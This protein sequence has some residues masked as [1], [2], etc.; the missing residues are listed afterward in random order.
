MT[1]TSSR[2]PEGTRARDRAAATTAGRRQVAVLAGQLVAGLGNLVVSVLLARL[3]LPG[4]YA[5]YTAFL[6]AYVM[7]HTIASSVTAAIAMD[8]ALHG[9]L[10]RR[11]LLGSLALA[12]LGVAVAPALAGPVGLPMLLVALLGLSAPSAVLLALAR[13][14]LYGTHRSV[15]AA[16]T[17]ATEPFGRAAVGLALVPV[18]GAGG[19][20]AGTVAAGYLALT[21]ALLAGRGAHVDADAAAARRGHWGTVL[22]FLLVAVV[23]AQ[24]VIIANKVLPGAEAGVIAAVATIGGAAYFATA[25]IPLVLMPSSGAEQKGSLAVALAAAAGISLAA[26]LVV[27]AIPASGYALVVGEAYRDAATYA[28]AYV[29][30]MAALGVAKVLV[31]RLCMNGRAWAGA[32]LVAL[33]VGLQLALLLRAEN[34][35]GIVTATL[36]ACLFL[37]LGAAALSPFAAP[38]AS[39]VG[40]VDAGGTTDRKAPETMTDTHARPTVEDPAPAPAATSDVAA[41]RS[42]ARAWLAEHWLLVVAL[43]VGLGLRLAV[44]RSI[45]IDE[46]ISIRQAQLGYGAMI[47][48]LAEN[49]VHPPG[50]HTLL[51]ALVHATGSTAEYVVRLPSLV[52]GMA[53]LVVAYAFARDLWDRRTANI[54]AIVFSV[55][56]VAVWYAQEARMY[57]LWMLFATLAAWAQLRVLRDV[58]RDGGRGRWADWAVFAVSSALAV[59][60]Q[61]F[62]ALPVLVA[63]ALM[64]GFVLRPTFRRMW[65]RWVVSGL[66]ALVLV[67]PLVPFALEQLGSVV[68]AGGGASTTPGQVGTDATAIA[69][70][71]PDVYA[72]VANTIWAIWGYHADSVMVLVSA[73]WPVVLIGALMGLGRGRSREVWVLALLTVVPVAILF[74]IG[75]ERRQLFELRYFTAAVPMTLLLLSRLTATWARGPVVRVLMP[76]ALVATLVL[77]LADQQVNQSN[78]RTYD[79]ASAVEWVQ[80]ESG[81]SD[82]L[83]VYAPVYLQD[84]MLYYDSGLPAVSSGKVDGDKRQLGLRAA[85]GGATSRAVPDVEMPQRVFVFGSFLSDASVSGNVGYVLAALEQGGYALDD[86]Y[87]T[88]NV[89]VWELVATD[90]VVGAVA[91]SG[92]VA[93]GGSPGTTR[94]RGADSTQASTGTATSGGSGSDTPRSGPE[95]AEAG[96]SA[97]TTTAWTGVD[98]GSSGGATTGGTAGGPGALALAAVPVLAVSRRRRAPRSLAYRHAVTEE[99]SR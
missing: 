61:W 89:R 38:P 91:G 72:I 43:V 42:G 24:D 63:Q 18:L 99:V 71:A 45:W 58:G 80:G 26:L 56:P 55:A 83:L 84:E 29:G 51:W 9:R 34:A 54:T 11:A 57:A 88:A 70:D 77:G 85:I 82:D 49:D 16:L 48:D 79:F 19:A 33:A 98:A 74:A 12:A 4:D 2:T 78:P 41:P 8:P 31:A 30:A 13:G 53:L 87:R 44:T 5:A 93:E 60:M 92:P 40:A 32:V 97:G 76:A 10:L 36:V 15:G 6:G 81:S 20:A 21:V 65:W 94:S 62:A 66:G 39:T 46:A 47:S 59:Y 27:A 22:T 68:A 69:S 73:L 90:D 95:A 23:A 50:F 28:P 67:L 52:A 37:L 3:L 25:T 35:T 64:L 14:R 7:L 86:Q 1:L 96:S 17:L 75:F